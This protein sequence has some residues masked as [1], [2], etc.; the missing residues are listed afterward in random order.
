M[1]S[2]DSKLTNPA[3][4][5]LDKRAP[6]LCAAAPGSNPDDLLSTKQ[7]AAWLGVSEQW[8]EI[9]RYRGYGPRYIRLA[10]RRVRYRREDVLTFLNSRVHACTSEY[11]KHTDGQT[12]RNQPPQLLSQTKAPAHTRKVRG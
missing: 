2:L 12:F 11:T 3:R 6:D 8:V 1:K 10:P 7:V 4:H 9:G 5:H